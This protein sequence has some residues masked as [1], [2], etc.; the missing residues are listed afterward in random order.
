[1]FVKVYWS[2]YLRFMN[3]ILCILCIS[4]GNKG[5]GVLLFG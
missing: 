2:V 1:M 4:K 3:F 5:L